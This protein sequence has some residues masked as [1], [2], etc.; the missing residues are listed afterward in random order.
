[1]IGKINNNISLKYSDIISIVPEEVI[2][3][4]YF[5]IKNIPTLISSPFR[6]DS[7]PSFGIFY[8]QNKIYY[9]D[10]GDN[11]KGN[12][13]ELLKRY[14]N[15]SFADLK[16]KLYNEFIK[17]IAISE[18]K[19]RINNSYINNK[20][21][22]KKELLFKIR[23]INKKDIEF[24]ESFGIS[25]S[26]LK[27]GNVYPLKNLWY[28][29]NSIKIDELCYIYIEHKDNIFSY[30]IYQPH[31]KLYK[32]I[33]TNN[34]SIWDLWEKLPKTGNKLIIT[35]SRKDALCI[36]NNLNI[37]ATSLQSEAYIPKESVIKE[38]KNRFKYIFILY[39]NDYKNKINNGHIYAEAIAKKFNLIQIEIPTYL[40]SKD[41]SDLY[42]NK[43]KDIFI[44]TLNTLID[45]NIK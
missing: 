31:N 23:N 5:D 37:P 18:Y 45:E 8:C 12:V 33:N 3:K 42:K 26:M 7:K 1:M 10:F 38:L 35:S 27:F 29:G 32:W 14:F 6:K 34:K 13:I 40:E 9:K 39:D 43:G 16:L 4:T 25:Q 15:L 44:K 20:K 2:L 11:T 30:K 36:W 22:S 28:N 21:T 17:N 19:Y 41:P 24:W